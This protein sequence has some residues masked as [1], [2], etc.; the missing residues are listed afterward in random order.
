[1]GRP[2][3]KPQGGGAP[4]QSGLKVVDNAKAEQS[5]SPG[6]AKTAAQDG[7]AAKPAADKA[8]ARR[9]LHPARVWPD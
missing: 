5:G 1:M 8:A 4:N 6:Q 7:D 2:Q 9:R 3:Q